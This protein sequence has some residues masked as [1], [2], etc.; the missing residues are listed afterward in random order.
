MKQMNRNCAAWNNT[1]GGTI[2]QALWSKVLLGIA[3]QAA[4]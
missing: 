4:Q 3:F 1:P 2:T